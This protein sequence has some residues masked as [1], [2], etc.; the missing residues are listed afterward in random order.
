MDLDLSLNNYSQINFTDAQQQIIDSKETSVLVN[1]VAGSGKTT[2]LM[3]LSTKYSNGLYLAFNKAI[4][5]DVL[6]KLPIGWYC[7]T[8]NSMGLG[9]VKQ[10]YPYSTVNFSKYQSKSMYTAAKLA[11]K[12]MSL[13]GNISNASWKRTCA[14]FKISINEI[15]SAKS[16]L[17]TG[18]ADTTQISGEDMLQY[19]IDNGWKTQHYDIVLV[20]ECQDLNP[21]QIEFLSC[22]KTDRI[23]FVGDTNQA[24]YGFIGSDPEAINKLKKLYQPQEYYL[25]TSF[26]C[27][28]K[29]LPT[30]NK[31]VPH[32]ISSKLGGS[33]TTVSRKT[34]KYV[35][36]CFIIARANNSLITLAYK[37][38]K[39]KQDFS[40]GK[41]F[42]KNIKRDFTRILRRCHTMTEVEQMLLSEKNKSITTAKKDNHSTDHIVDK[43]DSLF[44]IVEQCEDIDEILNFLKK[45]AAHE[46]T[47]SKRKLLTIHAVK[48]LE[49]DTVYYLDPSSREYM[50]SKMTSEWEKRQEDNL[51]YVACSRALQ[52]LIFVR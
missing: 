7:R 12:H 41:S 3:G 5:A 44:A 30:I 36:D 25:N 4:V 38:L 24:I 1:A 26:R 19:P 39:E 9:M 16:I 10:H 51:F 13:A 29:I 46:S 21:Q 17:K 15:S 28:K 22:I 45:L 11:T 6:P 42:V 27:P 14:R 37:F 31:I 43:Y 23:V 33:V 52:H 20:D 32:M 8:F 35:D 50:K 18:T 34:V 47:A 2:T 49:N 40:I 48:G